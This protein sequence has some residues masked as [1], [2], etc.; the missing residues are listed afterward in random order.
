MISNFCAPYFHISIAGIVKKLIIISYGTITY[1]RHSK[2]RNSVFA[3]IRIC[4]DFV[5][6]I[7]I[8]FSMLSFYWELFSSY[9][10]GNLN[11]T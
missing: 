3:P 1:N 6:V 5:S 11:T 9:N 4:I 2:M 7:H 8:R 10:N